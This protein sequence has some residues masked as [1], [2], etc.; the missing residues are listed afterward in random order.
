MRVLNEK[1]VG[2]VYLQFLANKLLYLSNGAR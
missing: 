2:K 1:R